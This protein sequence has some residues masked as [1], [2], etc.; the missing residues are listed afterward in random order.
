MCADRR[1]LHSPTAIWANV[2]L[3]VL[4]ATI[5]VAFTAWTFG[6]MVWLAFIPFEDSETHS[7]IQVPAGIFL[8][9][10]AIGACIGRA[11]GL[12]TFVSYIFRAPPKCSPRH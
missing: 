8:P 7:G 3:L 9:T 11:V 5:K 6:M 1:K 12:I 4:T 2:F 10:I